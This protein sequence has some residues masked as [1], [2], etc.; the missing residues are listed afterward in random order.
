MTLDAFMDLVFTSSKANRHQ[1]L[2]KLTKKKKK[3]MGIVGTISRILPSQFSYILDSTLS[4]WFVDG[5]S[6]LV[7]THAFCKNHTSIKILFLHLRL[8]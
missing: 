1:L 6:R 7:T 5:S 8:N 4:C 2:M 3:V